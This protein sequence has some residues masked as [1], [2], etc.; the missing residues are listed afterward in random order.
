MIDYFVLDLP[1]AVGVS[2]VADAGTSGAR[3]FFTDSGKS[4]ACAIN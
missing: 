1:I 2:G 4:F 3:A